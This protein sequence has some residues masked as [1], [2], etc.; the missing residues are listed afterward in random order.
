MKS[1]SQTLKRFLAFLLSAA[2]IVTYMPSGFLAYAAADEGQ[3]VAEQQAD[4][5]KGAVAVTDEANDEAKPEAETV[6]EPAAD[7][8]PEVQEAPAEEV[9]EEPAEPAQEDEPAAEEAEEEAAEEVVETTPDADAAE[10]NAGAVSE[11]AAPAESGAPEEEAAPEAETQTPEEKVEYPALSKDKTFGGFTVYVDAPEG[12]FPEGTTVEITDVSSTASVEESVQDLMGNTTEVV[13][14]VDI[15]FRYKGEEMEPANGKQVSVKFHSAEIGQLDDASVVHVTDEGEAEQVDAKITGNNATFTSDAFSVYVIVND[16]GTEETFR[17]TFEFEDIDSSG[18]YGPYQFNNKAGEKVTQQIAKTGSVL[19]PVGT[20]YHVGYDFEGWYIWDGSNWGNKV[21]FNDASFVGTVSADETVKVRAKYGNVVYIDYHENPYG[22]AEDIILTTMAVPKGSSV[23]V[24]DIK[25][26][27]PGAGKAFIGWAEDD[28]TEAVPSPY[29]AAA[30]VDLYPLFTGAHWLRFVGNGSGASYT[31]AICVYDN[32][33]LSEITKPAD[34]TRD[35][36]TF[37]DWYEAADGN[38]KF[39]WSGKLTEDKA[40]YAHWTPKTDVKYSV[41]YWVQNADD[42]QYTFVTSKEMTGT[43]GQ[44]TAAADLTQAEKNALSN[45]VDWKGFNI[46]EI[47]QTTINGNGSTVVNVLYDRKLVTLTFHK[48]GGGAPT[49]AEDPEGDYYRVTASP[50]GYYFY[51]TGNDSYTWLSTDQY[52]HYRDEGPLKYTSGDNITLYDQYWFLVTWYEESDAKATV[53]RYRK[54]QGADLTTITVKYG[55]DI[56]DLWPEN[57]GGGT[58]WYL[59]PSGGN[60]FVATLNTAPGEDTDYYYRSGSGSNTYKTKF[61][62][63]SVNGGNSFSEYTTAAVKFNQSPFT[64]ADDY[65]PIKGFRINAASDGDAQEIRETNGGDPAAVSDRNFNRSAAI[66][67]YYTNSER[68][69]RFYYLRNQYDIRFYSN[70]TEVKKE[71]N[72]YYEADISGKAPADYVVGKTKAKI[73]GKNVV[74]QGWFDNESCEGV[75]YALDKMPAGDLILYA[76]WAPEEYVVT[77]DPA[78]GSING[79]D[80]AGGDKTCLIVKYDDTVNEIATSRDYYAVDDSYD[81]TKYY[82]HI[83]SDIDAPEEERVAYYTTDQSLSTDGKTYAKEAGAYVFLGWYVGDSPYDFETKVTGPLT[84]TAKWRRTGAFHVAYQGVVDGIGGNVTSPEDAYADGAVITVSEAPKDITKGYVFDGWEVVN[85]SGSTLDDKDGNYYQPGDELTLDAENA[86]SNKVIHIQAHYTKVE[87]STDPV[88]VVPLV[89]DANGGALT[90]APDVTDKD[91]NKYSATVKDNVATYAKLPMNQEYDLSTISANVT[92]PSDE[93][94]EIAGWNTSKDAADN[95]TVEFKTNEIVG[96]DELPDESNTLYAVWK[97]AKAEVTV[98]HYLKGTTTKIAEDDTETVTIGENFTATPKTEYQGKA[99]TADSYDPKQTIKVAASGNEITV[100]YTLPLTIEAKTASKV[101][102]GDPLDG[103]YTVTG[104]LAADKDG[105]VSALGTA[106]SITNVSESPKDYLTKEDQDKI[107][108]IPEYYDVTYTPG[109]LTITPITEEYE[110]TVTGNSDTKVYNGGEQSVS[111]Y[112]VSDYDETITFTG[113][114]QDAAKA[115]AKGTNAG[116][117]T[118]AMT[119]ADFTATSPNYTNIKITVVPGTLEITPITEEYEI[120]VTGNS[121]TLVYNTEEQSVNGYEYST[122]DSTIEITKELAQ[123]DAKATAKGTNVGT[124]NMTMS[125]DD[126]A[127]T[128]KNYTNIT[129]KVVPGTLEITPVTQPYEI[130]VTGKNATKVYNAE[131]QSV[132]GYEYSDFDSTIEITKELAQDDAKATAKGTNVGTYNMTMSADDFAA[133]SK[134]YTNI[135]FKVV[136][137]KLEITQQTDEYVITVRGKSATE[138]YSGSEKSVSGYTIDEYDE[139]VT[140]TKELA[141]DDAKATAK[142]TDAGT[143]KMTM[144]ADDFAATSPNFSK[145]KIVVVPGTLTINPVE[146]EYKIKVTGNSDTKVYNTKEQSVKGYEFGD[147]DETI[148][149]TKKLDQNDAKAT[150]KGTNVGTYTMTMSADDF[151]AESKNYTNIVFEVE[152]GKLEITPVKDEYEIKVT[153]NSDTKV[154]NTEEQSVNGY[155]VSKYDETITFSGI[156]Q[157]DEKATAK[158]TN[159]GTYTMTMAE[160]DFSATSKNYENIKITVVPGTLEITPITDEYEITVTGKN[161]TKVYN[162]NEQSVNGYTVSEYDETITFTGLAQD[163]AKATAKGTNVGTYKMAMTDADFTATSDNYEKIKITVVPGKLEIT[164]VTDEYEIT[165]TGNSDTKV[166]NR[167]EQSVSGYTVSE[168]DETIDFKGLAQDAAKATAKGTNVG[169]YKMAMTEDDFSAESDNYTNIKITVV[170]G[171]LEITPV[172]DEYEITVTGNSDTKVYNR[173]EQSVNGYTVSDYDQTITFTGLAQDD[174]KATAKGTNAGTYTMTM[175]DAD[176]TAASDNYTNIKITVVPGTLEI[177]PVTDEYEITV[178]GNSDEKEY[179]GSEQSV[180]GY[181]VSDYDQTITFTGLAQ[182]DE[183][184]T[185][186]GT[187]AGTYTMTMAEADFTAASDNYTNIKITVV[188]GTLEITPVKSKVTVTI[189]G[190]K[191][192]KTYDAAEHSVSGYDV[193]ISN[194]LYKEAD[195]TF[196]PAE[197]A[198]LIDGVIGA[199]RTDAGTTKMGLDKDQFANNSDN[200]SNVVFKVKD[201]QIEIT[202]AKATVKAKDNAKVYGETDPALEATV[203]GII[204]GASIVYEVAR[205]AGENV[206]KYDITPSGDAV[207]GNYDVAYEKGKFE[208]TPAEITDT[209]EDPEDPDSKRFDVSI[210][211]DTKYNGEEQKQPVTVFDKKT[212]KDLVEGKD[213]TLSYSEDTVNVGQVEVTVKGK[214]NYSGTVLRTYKITPRNLVLTSA[215]DKKVYDGTALTNHKVTVGGDGL[216]KKDAEM[217]TFDVTGSQTLVGSSANTFTYKWT[218]GDEEEVQTGAIDTLKNYFTVYAAESKLANNYVIEKVEGTLTV[219]DDGVDNDKVVNKTHEDKSYKAGDEVTFTVK[220]TNIYDEAKTIALEEKEGVVLAQSLFENVKAGATV[221][222]TATYTLTEADA[223]AGS[224]E[225]VI[226][227]KFNG[228]DK[229]FTNNDKVVVE[230]EEEPEEDVI[231]DDDDDDGGNGGHGP[232]TGDDGFG[233]SLI[234]LLGAGAALGA[235]GARR[236]R[237]E[238]E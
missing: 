73:D 85:A 234:A 183:K 192:K 7:P 82:Y 124:Y 83:V 208:I 169:T 107:T 219:T 125:A 150:A 34:P 44:Q 46:K 115:T 218:D 138:I 66:G 77:F 161:A 154:Y 159:A 201:G 79:N 105:I 93:R 185:A 32:Q 26:P 100:Y 75:P 223:E 226:K 33:D 47:T 204:D 24:N 35:G 156:A 155:T 91:G 27:L 60:V 104:A 137:G 230:K 220:A 189:T 11:E 53:T 84:I 142:G 112:T 186:K 118:M 23:E 55:Q 9:T 176:F 28:G 216:A 215:S 119:E 65:S 70:G 25:A 188:P 212:Q 136:P 232:K 160:A 4:E 217:L 62:I 163:A 80:P 199:K 94:Y 59:T 145:I 140:F 224:F 165:V 38:T 86:D 231:D 123:D 19:E 134:N 13:K 114:A 74:F 2:L 88:S 235:I 64:T 3:T 178:T 158:G 174:A 54:E 30:N 20:P 184:A 45:K 213:F 117:Y 181:T 92:Y 90:Q 76:K 207:Q 228:V 1:K 167:N 50:N 99:V 51:K 179:N 229:V 103:E 162:K 95:G 6:E 98:H 108:G 36:Y 130:T 37:D 236:R 67:S 58:D 29:T 194:E 132:N 68:T 8:E 129:F 196:T 173:N 52:Y 78:G 151:A 177:T 39:N 146:D 56:H 211:E 203:E 72:I 221:T 168:Y 148:D 144:S 237:R 152:P 175:T 139:S 5:A 106:P 127:A 238:Q 166:Y 195:F 102:D 16:S 222:T 200:F 135:K 180:N 187:N 22:S 128:S 190:H 209:P 225:N 191:D 121:D 41:F 63:Q 89:F 61:M 205:A 87:D 120:T 197:D 43:A 12:A 233:G 116:T 101:Y 42:D 131:E 164:P 143:Y 126:F 227:A 49:Y 48:S 206:G 97:I 69:L 210:P 182:D 57:P 31:E 110:I 133:T 71:E 198:T 113:L 111:G 21:V 170:P 202:R 15:S 172:T 193:E 122:F 109:T 17:K 141:Q 147:Y 96:V 149:I 171:T 10:E 81:G 157:D 40:V 14:A 153:G 18:E 214:G